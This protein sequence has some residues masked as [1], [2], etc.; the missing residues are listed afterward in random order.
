M[1]LS[2]KVAIITGVSKGIGRATAE[3][4]VAKEIFG[5]AVISAGNP[6]E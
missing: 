2:G 5:G 4:L 3:A 1:E 6:A